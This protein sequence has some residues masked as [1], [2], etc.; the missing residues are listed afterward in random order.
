MQVYVKAVLGLL[1]L[2]LLLY[3]LIMQMFHDKQYE[4]VFHLLAHSVENRVHFFALSLSR[5]LQINCT[6]LTHFSR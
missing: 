5:S 1:R 6:V 3:Q 2:L 4:E